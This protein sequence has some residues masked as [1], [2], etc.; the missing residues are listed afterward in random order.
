MYTADGCKGGPGGFNRA[1]CIEASVDIPEGNCNW[2]GKGKAC[3]QTCPPSQIL[4]SQNTHV[5]GASTG[6]KT[7][8][9]A[10][11]C[12]TNLYSNAV[13]DCAESAA[14]KAISGGLNLRV[15]S[16][17][18][19]TEDLKGGGLDGPIG[20]LAECAA[21]AYADGLAGELA[22]LLGVAVAGNYIFNH[23]PGHWVSP[24]VIPRYSRQKLIWFLI[25][26]YI[27]RYEA[28]SFSQSEIWHI[29]SQIRQCVPRLLRTTLKR[30]A[31][32]V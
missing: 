12:C 8:Y 23:I 19:L 26:R 6:C 18:G 28:G 7:G 21:D 17:A 1:L 2:Y 13:M 3:G 15:K 4:I 29:H 27:L 9:Y 30:P 20:T 10:S 14:G 22:A 25:T 5:G 11:F 16:L 32:L 24:K 31:L